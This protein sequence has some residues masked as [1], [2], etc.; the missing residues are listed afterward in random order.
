[1]FCDNFAI[2]SILPAALDWPYCMVEN[3]VF[4]ACFDCAYSYVDFLVKREVLVRN[5][6]SLDF[7]SDVQKYIDTG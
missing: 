6:S 5:R 4:R 1:M 7:V 3:V 2:V